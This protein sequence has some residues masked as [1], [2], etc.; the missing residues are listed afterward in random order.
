M[1][2]AARS[3][4]RSQPSNWLGITPEWLAANVDQAVQED[5]ANL[6][7]VDGPPSPSQIAL[8][9][10]AF[11]DPGILSGSDLVHLDDYPDVRI[12]FKSGKTKAVFHSSSAE[13]S[14]A[15]WSVRLQGETFEAHDR[16]IGEALCPLLPDKFPNRAR[17]CGVNLRYEYSDR[18]FAAI[19]TRWKLAK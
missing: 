11:L 4:P 17:I 3:A 12:E 2:A 15:P 5:L 14:M 16:S 19:S 6:P 1:L 7:V 18:V 8:F 9:R 13:P 10:A